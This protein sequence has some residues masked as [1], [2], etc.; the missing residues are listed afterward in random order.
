MTVNARMVDQNWWITTLM[1]KEHNYCPLPLGK[2]L[3]PNCFL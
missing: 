2:F 3:R 1:I